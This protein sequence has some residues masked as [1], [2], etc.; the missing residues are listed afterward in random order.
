[1][2]DLS[3]AIDSL[4]ENRQ[5][6]ILIGLTGRTGSGCSSAAELLARDVRKLKLPKPKL[7]DNNEDRKYRI[8]YDFSKK[9]WKKFHWIQLKDVIT[10]FILENTFDEFLS[11]STKLIKKVEKSKLEAVLRGKIEKEFSALHEERM[12]LKKLRDE[13]EQ[14]PVIDQEK[15]KERREKSY[16]FY[17]ETVPPFTD[18]LK[19]V[20]NE[21]AGDSYTSIYQAAGDNIRSSGN[22]L[23]ETF[24]SKNILRLASRVNKLI[25]IFTNRAKPTKE[26]VYVVIDAIRNPFEAI[27]FRERYAAFYLVSIN[28]HNEDR[29]HRLKKIL[30]LN[31]EQ[32]TNIDYK[33][34]ERNLKGDDFFY[35]QNISKCI[36][37]ADIHL[38]NPQ[39]GENDFTTLKKQLA[40]Y[41]SLIMH[42]GL[43]TPSMKERCMQV[44]YTAK[45]N[46]ACL[47]R[48]VG[49]SVTDENYSIK[50]I[51]WNNSAEG[52]PPCALRN[53]EHLLDNEDQEAYSHYEKNNT[54]FRELVRVKYQEKIDSK[55]IAKKLRGRNIAYCFK[56]LQNSLEN[57]KNQVHTRSLHA[58]ENAFLQL[59]K[60][61]GTGIKGGILFTTASPCELCSKKA[62]QLGIKRVIY[63]DPYPGIAKEHIL[64]IGPNSPK[65]ELFHG[66][67]GR[68]YNHLFEPILP[69]KDELSFVLGFK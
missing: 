52:Q 11:Y 30:N 8:I 59:A 3:L 27:F 25:K 32:L 46:S 61:G 2:S 69:Y 51:G 29:V 15:V 21:L 4:Y 65:L 42:P 31:E 45:L 12:E 13:T 7:T 67:I 66:A 17:F 26:E 48:Q 53:I 24:D 6:F 54:K 39:G 63:I 22:A 5:K 28:T 16:K 60:Y 41:V 14:A 62:Y 37:I 36:E 18:N 34:Y 64:S 23:D 1:M 20:F 40:W 44:A 56:D 43:I 68:A 49:A 19:K 47:S 57:E 38:N 55:D 35:S 9:N 58:E 10:S 50:S 33:E